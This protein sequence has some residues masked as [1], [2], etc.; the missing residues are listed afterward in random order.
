MMGGSHRHMSTP[1]QRKR[2]LSAASTPRGAVTGLARNK[3]EPR[4]D[5]HPRLGSQG[6]W[7]PPHHTESHPDSPAMVGGARRQASLACR[8]SP[9]RAEPLPD[10]P[11]T[12]GARTG[13]H[14]CPC[15]RCRSPPH[16]R[17]C[18]RTRPQ[19]GRRAP[20]LAAHVKALYLVLVISDN[21]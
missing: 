20:T 15:E 3:G 6:C 16:I 12:E 14:P 18:Y 17:S 10:S 13:T 2:G 5:K 11:A 7:P 21:A 9:H 8:S 4:T 1:R 19:G